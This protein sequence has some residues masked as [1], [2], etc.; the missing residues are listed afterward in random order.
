MMLQHHFLLVSMTLSVKENLF[1]FLDTMSHLSFSYWEVWPR[2]LYPSTPTPVRRHIIKPH[3]LLFVCTQ[4]EINVPGWNSSIGELSALCVSRK[5]TLLRSPHLLTYPPS[6]SHTHTHT[7]REPQQQ[8]AT[9]PLHPTSSGRL[10]SVKGWYNKVL[11]PFLPAS[12]LLRSSHPF[13]LPN[14]K[15]QRTGALF[16]L[17]LC[18]VLQANTLQNR[19]SLEDSPV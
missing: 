1:A 13:L 9:Q 5:T 8:S 16:S 2:G 19:G 10:T 14:P 15:P 12:I 4:D 11:S 3:T 17:Q 7:R 18:T 6:L